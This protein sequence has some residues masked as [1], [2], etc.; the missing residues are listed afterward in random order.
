[1]QHGYTALHIA[2]ENNH[3]AIVS[4]LVERRANV[5]ATTDVS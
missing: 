1:V 4:S 3:A 5:N 2:A